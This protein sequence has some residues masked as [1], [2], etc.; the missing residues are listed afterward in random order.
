MPPNVE[1][2]IRKDICVTNKPLTQ[3]IINTNGNLKVG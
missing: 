1:N 2:P 3:V